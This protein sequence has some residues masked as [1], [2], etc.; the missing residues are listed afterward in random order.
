MDK[1]HLKDS[2]QNLWKSVCISFLELRKILPLSVPTAITLSSCTVTQA[3]SAFSL[4]IAV[5]CRENF[6]KPQSVQGVS[7]INIYRFID[8]M[9]IYYNYYK[10]FCHPFTFESGPFKKSSLAVTDYWSRKR[11]VPQSPVQTLSWWGFHVWQTSVA[12]GAQSE[13]SA[14]SHHSPASAAAP[15]LWR[16]KQISQKS[17]PR[18][19]NT[20]WLNVGNITYITPAQILIII[21]S[22]R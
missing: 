10:L 1:S 14:S 20:K 21:R 11:A 17:H 5:H 18:Y 12:R 2:L 6:R 3:T 13:S 7:T 22:T 9:I 15:C 16:A 4:D 19:L 8:A